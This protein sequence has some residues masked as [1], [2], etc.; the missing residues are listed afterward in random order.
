MT[1]L[2]ETSLIKHTQLRIAMTH[3][4]EHIACLDSRKAATCYKSSIGNMPMST[5][6]KI[7]Q[8]DTTACTL[9]GVTNTPTWRFFTWHFTTYNAQRQHAWMTHVINGE[10]MQ[11]TCSY[12]HLHTFGRSIARAERLGPVGLWNKFCTLQSSLWSPRPIHSSSRSFF[13]RL[14]C[15]AGATH[16][17]CISSPLRPHLG[18]LGCSVWSLTSCFWPKHLCPQLGHRH[19]WAC[20]PLHQSQTVTKPS[21]PVEEEADDI[22]SSEKISTTP[23]AGSKLLTTS[24]FVPSTALTSSCPSTFPETSSVCCSGWRNAGVFRWNTGAGVPGTSRLWSRKYSALFWSEK[25]GRGPDHC[26]DP[27]QFSNWSYSQIPAVDTVRV[28]PSNR[29]SSLRALG[30]IWH[31][32]LIISV[33]EGA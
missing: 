30:G 24:V 14:S 17:C 4:V 32:R 31:D 6:S 5:C 3:L 26:N 29:R 25:K 28:L 9:Q 22:E 23:S 2:I 7:T 1:R 8:T 18:H 11:L 20:V 15:C 21:E 12:D 13:R 19:P 27:S 16:R 33:Q 10:M